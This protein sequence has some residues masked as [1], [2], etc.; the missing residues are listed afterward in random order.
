MS[1]AENI[2][3]SVVENQ[4]RP[5]SA[6]A[7]RMRRL[8]ERRRSGWTRI[9]SVAVSSKDA[10]ALFER[11]F[12]LPERM[13]ARPSAAGVGTAAALHPVTGHCAPTDGK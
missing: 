8:R 9:G 5:P 7:L 6:G 3:M 4:D 1:T 10:R 11:G 2:P 12:L 13:V